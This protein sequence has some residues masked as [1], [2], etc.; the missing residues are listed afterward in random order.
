MIRVF[1]QMEWHENNGEGPPPADGM[2]WWAFR[3]FGG[4][5]YYEADALLR[6]KERAGVDCYLVVT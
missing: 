5:E 1:W 6:A 2:H 3:D 4:D